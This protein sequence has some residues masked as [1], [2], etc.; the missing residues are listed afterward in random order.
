MKTI[1]DRAGKVKIAMMEV[2]GII[3]DFRMQ[4]VGG[5]LGAW[6]LWNT[7]ILPSLIAN[8]GTWTELPT[9]AVDLCDE[10]HNLFLRIML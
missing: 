7:A 2:K 9:K 8:C 3:E 5:I 6:D 1:E 4:A 10:L